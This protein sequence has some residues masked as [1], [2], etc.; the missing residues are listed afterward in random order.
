MFSPPT[1]PTHRAPGRAVVNYRGMAAPMG[2]SIGGAAVLG[3]V[4]ATGSLVAIPE[5]DAVTS[6]QLS[7][8]ATGITVAPADLS[9]AAQKELDTYTALVLRPGARGDAISFLQARLNDRGANIAVDGKYGPATRKAV[10]AVQTNGGV[11]ADGVVGPYTW[12]ILVNYSAEEAPAH[13]PES[14][15]SSRSSASSAASDEARYAPQKLR[16]GSRGEAVSFLQARLNDRGAKIAVDGK[17][18]PATR[19][20]VRAVQTN[21]GVAVDGVVGPATWNIMFNVSASDAPATI[22]GGSSSG[23]SSGS[24][25]GSSSSYIG[26]VLRYGDRGDAVRYLQARLNDR[27]AGIPEDGKFGPATRSAVRALQSNGGNRA[28]GVVGPATWDLLVNTSAKDVPANA[29]EAAPRWDGD[30][31]VALAKE[32]IGVPYV[33]GG[34]NPA[35]GLDCSGLVKYVYNAHGITVPRTAKNQ[36]F[37]GRIIPRSEAKPGDLVA[38]SAGNWGHIGI[39]AGNGKIVDAGSSKGRVVYRDIWNSPHVFVTYR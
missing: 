33:W 28:D 24:G 5:A 7:G 3:A 19:T 9:P 35:T 25:G 31:M 26:T 30:S 2:R 20:A 21:G 14:S 36:T 4:T 6:A 8:V 17:F 39:Y 27:D 23:G 38:F 10:M 11:S 13:L 22:K 16:Y 37:G 34:S 18:G 15:S 1:R 29:E 32:Q 12:N